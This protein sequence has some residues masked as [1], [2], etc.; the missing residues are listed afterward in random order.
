[1]SQ[2]YKRYIAR[3]VRD[4]QYKYLHHT[5][6][7]EALS[8]T[9]Y[10][11]LRGGKSLRSHPRPGYT[12]NSEDVG[13]L[14]VGGP[15]LMN[16]MF[17]GN[18]GDSDSGSDSESDISDDE[19]TY[20]DPNFKNIKGAGFWG[21][22]GNELKSGLSKGAKA[23][24]HDVIVP[25]GTSMAKDYVKKKMTGTGRPRGRPRKHYVHHDVRLIEPEEHHKPVEKRKRGRPRKQHLNGS[26]FWKDFGHGFV[27]GIKGST[28]VASKVLPIAT[29]L[30]PEIA[31]LTGAVL[32]TNQLIN[33]GSGRRPRGGN[34]IWD[35]IKKGA[36]VVGRVA[37][38]IAKEIFHDVIVPAG[39]EMAKNY[40]KSKMGGRRRCVGGASELY[41]PAVMRGGAKSGGA[42][43]ARGELIKKVMA[44]Y[45]C[46]L[47]QAS[48][49]IKE[50]NLM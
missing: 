17:N 24:F 34:K 1:M 11:N 28:K 41:P 3:K 4:N 15:T 8:T 36:K 29:M 40:V 42:R 44:K 39:T 9:Q 30:A 25:V 46:N 2:E 49:Y 19:Y 43:T 6:Q 5:D 22:V 23:V 21:D 13:T 47:G 33:K 45:K 26:G 20:V 27:Q 35:N 14:F 7:P 18:I 10:Q 16:R 37:A 12:Q 31:P 50:H 32:A 48:K 38:P